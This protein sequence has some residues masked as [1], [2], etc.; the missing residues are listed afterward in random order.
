MILFLANISYAVAVREDD[1]PGAQGMKS[2][3]VQTMWCPLADIIVL[4][5][6][7]HADAAE[8]GQP[9]HAEEEGQEKIQQEND[10]PEQDK[11]KPEVKDFEPSEKI[12]AEKAVDFPA[13][14]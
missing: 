1:R 2:E 13:D 6:N 12:D 10:S 7:D 9:V 4:A 14:I 11:K 5:Q 3:K 8:P